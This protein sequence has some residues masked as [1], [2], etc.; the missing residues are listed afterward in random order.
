MQYWQNRLRI[1]N[2]SIR[3]TLKGNRP[4]D[5]RIHFC[6][7]AIISATYLV[8]HL[9][10]SVLELALCHMIKYT[11]QVFKRPAT[12]ATMTHSMAALILARKQRDGIAMYLGQSASRGQ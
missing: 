4:L 7:G 1:A 3:A 9:R 6:I 12:L 5:G 2:Y 8:W 11:I 10:H